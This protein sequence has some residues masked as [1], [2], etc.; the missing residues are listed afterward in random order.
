MSDHAT[1]G[2]DPHGEA[3]AA[4]LGGINL[5]AWGAAALGVAIG[6]LTAAAIAI[7]AGAL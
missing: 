3:E 4:P 7:S 2:H 6:L 5:A 1:S